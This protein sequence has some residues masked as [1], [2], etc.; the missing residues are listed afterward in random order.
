TESDPI[1][2]A[3][4]PGYMTGAE[5]SNSFVE[6]EVDPVWAAASGSVV[7]T[8][9]DPVWVAAEPGYLTGAE[10]SNSFVKVSGGAVAGSL[11]VVTLVAT[12]V[13]VHS[14]TANGMTVEGA[15]GGLGDDAY[16]L[17]QQ[18]AIFGYDG[19]DKRTVVQAMGNKGMEF[20]VNTNP[21]GEGTVMML[22]TDGD[23]GIGTEAPDEHV[24]VYSPTDDVSL[25]IQTDKADGLASVILQN[26]AQQFE[27]RV[28]A[29]DNLVIRDVTNGKDIIVV[30]D[31]AS[32]YAMWV[33]ANVV[34]LNTPG[35]DKDFAV[36]ATNK[37][38]A[39]FVEGS[40]GD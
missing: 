35:Y 23:V 31:G 36:E 12:N 17:V 15:G 21:F 27:V 28:D 10:A 9:S 18:R 1:W 14:A 32:K 26:D 40:S 2:V 5:S 24:H 3:A 8:E 7:Y 39:F 34:T 33:G 4:E 19:G 16:I 29:G 30:I 6:T 37:P 25:K 20:N 13:D 38:F 22:A 11:S